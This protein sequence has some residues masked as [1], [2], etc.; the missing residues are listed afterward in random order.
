[1][2]NKLLTIAFMV[3]ICGT[4]II[5]LLVKDVEVS[6]TER[7]TLMQFPKVSVESIL[8]GDWMDDFEDYANDQFVGRD[9]M[10]SVQSLMRNVLLQQKDTNGLFMK[11]GV[12]YKMDYKVNEGSIRHFV[13]VIESIQSMFSEDNKMYLAIIPDKNYYLENAEILTLDYDYLYNEVGD[14]VDNQIN[15]K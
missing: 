3:M 13:E 8:S 4:F 10:G 6:S 9:L 11:D 12:I 1:M 5:N 2:K 14:L 7:R 15:V